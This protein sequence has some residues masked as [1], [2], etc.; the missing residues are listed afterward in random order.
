MKLQDLGIISFT[1]SENINYNSVCGNMAYK[2]GG[3]N[4]I[5]SKQK[6]RVYLQCILSKDLKVLREIISNWR[7]ETQ[8]GILWKIL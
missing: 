4:D 1:F 7:S 5:F 6:Q 8:G 3:W 2:E